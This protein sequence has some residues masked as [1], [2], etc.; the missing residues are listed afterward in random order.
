MDHS[1]NEQANNILIHVIKWLKERYGVTYQVFGHVP[2]Q[3]GVLIHH[4]LVPD[5]DKLPPLNCTVRYGKVGTIV[6]IL[7]TGHL[8]A[9]QENIESVIDIGETYVHEK[10]GGKYIVRGLSLNEETSEIMVSYAKHIKLKHDVENV[11]SINEIL[12]ASRMYDIT[13]WVRPMSEFAVK[14][15]C[16]GEKYS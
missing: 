15:K 6:S 9:T 7:G 2:S 12:E 10:S 4:Q 8:L 3:D 16:L 5:S 1:I 11:E 14:F 13:Q